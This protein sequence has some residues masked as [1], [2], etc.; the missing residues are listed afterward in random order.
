[1]LDALLHPRFTRQRLC[2]RRRRET[3]KDQIPHSR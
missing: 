1:L 2:G 3:E